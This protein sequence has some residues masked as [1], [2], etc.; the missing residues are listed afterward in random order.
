MTLE[1]A[2]WPLCVHTHVCIY[3]HSHLHAHTHTPSPNH[4]GS[5]YV[6]TDKHWKIS[7]A[8][9]TSFQLPGP[10]PSPSYLLYLPAPRHWITDRLACFPT[11]NQGL[12]WEDDSGPNFHPEIKLSLSVSGLRGNQSERGEWGRSRQSLRVGFLV[13]HKGNPALQP[14]VLTANKPKQPFSTML[15]QMLQASYLVTP[16]SLQCTGNPHQEP[17]QIWHTERRQA[18]RSFP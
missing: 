9:H 7:E 10:F 2:L 6:C 17:R 3:L 18:C 15:S 14:R 8:Q 4:N 5:Q 16:S 11:N 13:E 12:G 1:V